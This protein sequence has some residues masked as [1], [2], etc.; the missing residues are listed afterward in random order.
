MERVPTL[1][2]AALSI[3]RSSMITSR[4]ISPDRTI[5]KYIVS[6][7]CIDIFYRFPFLRSQSAKTENRAPAPGTLWV[8]V[9]GESRSTMLPQAKTQ[10]LC[11][12]EAFYHRFR[13]ARFEV[14]GVTAHCCQITS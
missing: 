4:I 10:N 12:A 8:R 5:E 6:R 13:Y 3:G 1:A 2:N 9:P 14:S 11:I 7:K